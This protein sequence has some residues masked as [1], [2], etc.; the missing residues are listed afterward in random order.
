MITNDLA[1]TLA[2]I[3]YVFID[4]GGVLTDNAARRPIYQRLV[5]EYFVRRYGGTQT[6][7]E[8]ANTDTAPRAWARFLERVA[9][10]DEHM[11]IKQAVWLYQADWLRLLF[12]AKGL[13][14]PEGEDE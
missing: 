8:E 7:W 10:W 2:G 12:D 11:S 3:D 14:P 6:A 4:N 5:G 13:Q 1:S 9:H